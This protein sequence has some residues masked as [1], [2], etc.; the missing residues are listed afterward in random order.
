VRVVYE[1]RYR[2]QSFEL[3]IAGEADAAPDQLRDAFEHEHE[4]RYGYRDAEQELEL[5]TIRVTAT[6]EGVD[7]ALA[8]ADE[9][10]ELE[11]STREAILD[12]ERIEL[13]VRRGVPTPDT[14]LDGP[15]VIELPESTLLIPSGWKA[16]VDE[17]GTIRMVRAR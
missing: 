4:E 1:L 13:A 14:Q 5:V 15:A 12:G 9:D 8:G 2:G 11:R 3:P 10:A 6:A 16:E 17:T 7:V